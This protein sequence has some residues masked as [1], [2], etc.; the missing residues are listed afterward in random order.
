M[1]CLNKH[2]CHTNLKAFNNTISSLGFQLLSLLNLI[3]IKE[4][5]KKM[6]NFSMQFEHCWCPSTSAWVL[7]L[8]M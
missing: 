6:S 8:N 3:Q 1:L 2:H 7:G 4:V 5:T